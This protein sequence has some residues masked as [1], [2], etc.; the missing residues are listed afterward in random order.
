M[1]T[2]SQPS[3]QRLAKAVEALDAITDINDIEA[4]NAAGDEL[5]LAA[6]AVLAAPDDAAELRAVKALHV[7]AKGMTPPRA[8]SYSPTDGMWWATQFTDGGKHPFIQES[9]PTATELC[10]KLGVPHD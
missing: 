6:R 4:D 9:A 8:V 1:T 5:L 7:W 3:R 10:K 2:H